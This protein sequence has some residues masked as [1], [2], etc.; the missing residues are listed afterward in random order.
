MSHGDYVS[1][2]FAD[3]LSGK[4]RIPLGDLLHLRAPPS[5]KLLLVTAQGLRDTAARNECFS[6]ARKLNWDRRFPHLLLK[7]VLQ[8][9]SPGS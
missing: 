5:Q 3:A 7:Q 8:I 2:A 4:A 6:L 1:R 9:Q